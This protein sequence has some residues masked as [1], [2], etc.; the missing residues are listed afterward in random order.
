MVQAVGQ[1]GPKIKRSMPKCSIS[2][3]KQCSMRGQALGPSDC[4]SPLITCNPGL[5]DLLAPTVQH[6][7]PLALEPRIKGGIALPLE[8]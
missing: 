8:W 7:V 6:S 4:G 5:M 2:S 3:L 1:T